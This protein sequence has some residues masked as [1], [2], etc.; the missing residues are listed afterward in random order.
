MNATRRKAIK[1]AVYELQSKIVEA[2]EI[3]RDTLEDLYS[4]EE[5]CYENSPESIQNSERGEA[6]NTAMEAIE[7]F[8]G[9][10]EDGDLISSDDISELLEGCGIE[11]DLYD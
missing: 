11:G 5:S 4:E 9:L 6:M 2:C 7:T 10:I 1:A 3:C 8:K